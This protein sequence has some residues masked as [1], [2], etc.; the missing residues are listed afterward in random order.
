MNLHLRCA[1][2]AVILSAHTVQAQS[3]ADRLVGVYDL[4]TGEPLADVQII[5]LGTELAWRTSNSGLALLRNLPAGQ[6]IL[7]VRRLGYQPHSEFVT[8]S[9]RDTVPLTLVLKPLPLLLPEV[10]VNARE[11]RYE[12]RLSGFLSRRRSSSASFSS[13]FTEEDLRKW[14][15][16]RW[17]DA[18]ARTGGVQ[19]DVRGNIRI[20][21]CRRFS[22]YLDGVMLSDNDLEAI[23]LVEVAAV[24]VYRGP[25]Q[26]PTQFNVTGR[27]CGAVIVWTK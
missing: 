11:E 21:G 23:P 25:A 19:G 8:L 5:L 14:G 6:H 20:R 17:S 18:L 27:D 2:V 16:V 7:R 26:I 24:E 4:E 9:P 15:A 12:R 1:V 22:V 10:M 13:F 3:A